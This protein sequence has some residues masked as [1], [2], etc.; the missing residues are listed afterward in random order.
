VTFRHGFSVIPPAQSVAFFAVNSKDSLACRYRLAGALRR[1]VTIRRGFCGA[2]V[3]FG[4]HG[5]RLFGF[6]DTLSGGYDRKS[7][8]KNT[9]SVANTAFIFLLAGYNF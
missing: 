5:Q 8:N 4:L 3:F 9:V 7:I 6:N 1:A 2:G